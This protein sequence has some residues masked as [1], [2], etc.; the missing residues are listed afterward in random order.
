[1][2][3][4]SHSIVIKNMMTLATGASFGRIFGFLSIPI[5]TR[6]YSPE[7]MG[8]LSVFIALTAVLIPFGTLRYSV[9]IPLPR[10]NAS[11]QNLAFVC[12]LSLIFMTTFFSILFWLLPNEIYAALSLEQ[13]SPFWWLIPIVIFSVGLHEILNSWSTRQKEFKAI[14]KT[15]ISQSISGAGI[16]ILLG[17]YGIKPLGLLIGHTFSQAGGILLLLKVFKKGFNKRNIS[18]TR[19]FFSL[20]RYSD[21]PR[22][23]LISQFLL[24][25]SAQAPLLFS[26]FLYDKEVVGQLGLALSTLAIPISV[27]GTTT[28]QAYYAEISKIGK[29]QPIDIF[30]VTKGVVKKL[31]LLSLPAFFILFLFGPELFELIFGDKWKKA[32]LFSQILSLYLMAQFISSP[33]VNVLSVFEKQAKFLFINIVRSLIV[34]TTFSI[35]YFYN[36]TYTKVFLIYSISISIHYF[37]TLY[38]IVSFLKF[39]IRDSNL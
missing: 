28:S 1:M 13:L 4:S 26:N 10:L 14:A 31:F 9:A 27:F 39:K 30:H 29:E 35:G 38:S 16:K 7:D 23:R 18:I 6:I 2:T 37:L 3:I 24:I 5:I 25:F 20:K 34:I 19:L 32:G 22:Y 12:F 36:L 21:F 11:A 33:V 15:Q 8:T 17:L